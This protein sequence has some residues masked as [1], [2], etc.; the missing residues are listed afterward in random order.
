M[1]KGAGRY[2]KTFIEPF[3]LLIIAET[4]IHGYEIANR[5]SEFGI[6]LIGLGQMGN[7]YRILTKL[8][9]EKL[10]YSKWDTNR[11]GPS[12]KIYYITPKGIEYLK[13]SK[14][15]LL[16]V[17]KVIDKFIMKVSKI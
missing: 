2:R 8:E 3:I 6:Q 16:K 10:I 4:P 15:E 13:K 5:L 17:K 9:N 11:Q 12:K 14:E 1:K 7:L